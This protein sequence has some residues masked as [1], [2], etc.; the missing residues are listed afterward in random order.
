ML[1]LG[2]DEFE[3]LAVLVI[4]LGLW[5]ALSWD[6]AGGGGCL[7]WKVRKSFGPQKSSAQVGG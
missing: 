6:P 2:V 1:F 5:L 3:M 7:F 4:L